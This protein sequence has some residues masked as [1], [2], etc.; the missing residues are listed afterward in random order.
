MHR[1]WFLFYAAVTLLCTCQCLAQ[2][3]EGTPPAKFRWRPFIEES[4]QTANSM[5]YEGVGLYSRAGGEFWFRR[6]TVSVLGSLSTT[7]KYVTHSGTSVGTDANAYYNVT[8]HFFF[9]G[10]LTWGRLITSEWSKSSS[11]PYLGGGFG[12]RNFSTTYDY[13]ATGTDHSNDVT[14]HRFKVMVPITSGDFYLV[15]RMA[16]YSAH[17]TDCATCSRQ[18]G[19]EA[20]FGILLRFR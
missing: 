20:Q 8:R 15:Y 14:G 3:N 7:D 9:G 11:H 17:E 6:T 12:A 13:V 2:A 19:R 18:W 16:W 4:V 5:G 10:G 1:S